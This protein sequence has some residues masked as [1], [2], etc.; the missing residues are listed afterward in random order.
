MLWEVDIYPAP[1][2]RIGRRSAVAAAAADWDWPSSC[3]VVGRAR[4]SDPRRARRRAGGPDRRR[5]AGRPRGRADRRRP[6]GR[7]ALVGPESPCIKRR[8]RP[9]W[10]VVHVLPKPGVMDPVAQSALAAI[11]DLGIRGRGRPHAAESTGSPALADERLA[12]ALLEGAG[13]RRHRAGDRRPAAASSG[14]SSARPTSSSSSPCR[15]A[16]WTTRPWSG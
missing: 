15:S 4:L 3:G 16:R 13:Q 9:H 14:W 7:S 10:Q 6:S 5:T 2:N 11:A 1:G 12:A 8:K